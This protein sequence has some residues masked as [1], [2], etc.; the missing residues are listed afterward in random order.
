MDINP[1]PCQDIDRSG[2]IILVVGDG[3]QKMRL[4][5]CSHA[6]RLVSP[7]LHA[8]VK[9]SLREAVNQIPLGPR[10]ISLPDDDPEAFT[11]LC[12]IAHHRFPSVQN[13]SFSLFERLSILTDKYL[14]T[15]ATM[16]LSTIS[17]LLQF[18]PDVIHHMDGGLEKLLQL[19]YVSYAFNHQDSFTRVTRGVLEKCNN[20]MLLTI[21]RTG[22]GYEI[23]P[24]GFIGKLF[25]R[26]GSGVR[27]RLTP[28]QE[29]STGY[30]ESF[31]KKAF[32]QIEGVLKPYLEEVTTSLA[33]SGPLRQNHR[34]TS[35]PWNI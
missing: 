32:N 5:V 23:L 31:M 19:L 7:A 25:L 24:V 21:E 9:A 34:L 26:I 14:T 3:D 6:L 30:Q 15:E 10:E 17:F 2:D 16:P 28:V 13:I 35:T 27:T 8:I 11:L 12:K 33:I 18:N 22:R 20:L 1:T 4:R 29:S